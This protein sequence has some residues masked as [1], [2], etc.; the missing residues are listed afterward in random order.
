LEKAEAFTVFNIGRNL[1]G[2]ASSN[3]SQYLEFAVRW[4]KAAIFSYS[5]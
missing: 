1:A 3:I 5:R 4:C 2:I